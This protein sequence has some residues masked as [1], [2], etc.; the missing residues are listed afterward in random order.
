MSSYLLNR[1]V[2]AVLVLFTIS[3]ISFG[4]LRTS[5]DLALQMAGPEAGAQYLAF[6]NKEYGF[7]RPLPVQYLS[8]LG[9]ALRGD[10]GASY[11]FHQPVADLL[12][13]R[14]PVTLTLGA[15]AITLALLVSIPLGVLAAVREDS[16]VDKLVQF[17]ALVGQATP[18]FWLAFVL[19]LIFG[20]RL[21]ILP[22]SGT[23]TPLHYVMPAMVLA[24]GSMPALTRIVRSGMVDALAADYV[25]TARAKGL[26]KRTVVAVHA[27]RNALVPVVSVSSVQFGY[28]LGGSIIVETVFALDGVGYFTWQ[29]ISQGDYPV[30]QAT[31]LM[32]SGFY[33]ALTLFADLFNM[34]IDPRLRL[35]AAR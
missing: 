18:H 33:I 28:L 13:G 3:M 21:A 19:M 8:W 15:L 24:A 27:L 34:A 30:V 12:A 6:L 4:L 22:I 23:G 29:A 10:F 17:I 35:G 20:I 32:V 2:S 7:D 25:R 26:R 31:L 14:L 11:Y 9:D 5:G 1:L 16:W